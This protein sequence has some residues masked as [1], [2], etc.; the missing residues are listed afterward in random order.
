MNRLLPRLPDRLPIV[1]TAEQAECGLA[2]VA[3]ICRYYGHGM[4]LNGFRQRFEVSQNG[5]TLRTLMHITSQMHLA[6]RAFRTEIHTLS[7]VKLPAILHWD[8][9]HFVVLKRIGRRRA[10]VHDPAFGIRTLSRDA[11]SDHFTGVVLE[12]TPSADFSRIAALSPLKPSHLWSKITGVWPVALQVLALSATLQVA[13]FAIPFQI[14]L[15]IDQA[16]EQGDLDFLAVVAVGFALLV[17]VYALTEA[18]RNWSLHVLA[19]TV[20]YQIVGNIFRHLLRLPA[21]FFEKRHIGDILSRMGSTKSIQEALTHGMVGVAIDGTMAI[22]AA[23]LLLAYSTQLAVVVLFSLL[24]Y[25][26]VT[27]FFYP[28]MKERSNEQ[29]IS[30]AVEQSYLMETVRGATTIK[31]LGG[32]IDREA[33]WRNRYAEAINTALRFDRLEVVLKAIQSAII[34]LQSVAVVYIGARLILTGSGFS[35]GMLMAFL[36]F[37]QTFSDRIASLV[38]EIVQFR[39]LKVHLDRLADIVTTPTEVADELGVSYDKTIGT[40]EMVNVS[41]RYASAEPLILDSVNFK[42]EPGEFVAITGPSG[43]GK[44]TLFKVLLGLH[45]P[46]SGK[47][48]VNGSP[49]SPQHWQLYRRQIGAVMQDDRLLSGSIADNIAFFQADLSMDRVIEAARA[50]RVH[51]DII[52]M[53]MQYRSLIGDMGSSLSGGQRQRVLLARALYRQPQLLLLDEGTANLDE[54]A[55]EAIADI[56]SEMTI[57]R[58]VIAHRPALMNRAT[59]LIEVNNGQITVVPRDIKKSCKRFD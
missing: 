36:S 20:L 34:G 47:V 35:I 3:M 11:L 23:I 54:R 33:N 51:D 39:L 52:R 55:E 1:Q 32:E 13:A 58:I 50:A 31:V 9:N 26:F 28:L 12:L 27:A 2:C 8:L 56:L 24:I 29:L 14:Q 43:G 42:I 22:V 40:L 19:A 10:V 15:V 7:K 16:V 37:R 38:G 18:L 17:V 53:P 44:T 41:F 49:V 30:S 4:D 25:L 48:L 21:S 57:T 45:Y 6:P 46:V 59:T 5:M